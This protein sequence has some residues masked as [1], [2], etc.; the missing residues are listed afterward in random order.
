MPPIK[1]K[2]RKNHL[3]AIRRIRG[4]RQKQMAYLLGLRGAQMVSRYEAG[5]VLP[6][7]ETALTMEIVLGARLSEIYVDLYHDLA[8]RAWKRED[9][10]PT[11]HGRPICRR[12]CGEDNCSNDNSGKSGGWTRELPP[13]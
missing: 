9:S 4:Y 11:A 12:V 8:V 5:T 2:V 7:L 13:A 10:L 6:S 1:T 3:Y